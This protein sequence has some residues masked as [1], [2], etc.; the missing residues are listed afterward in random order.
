MAVASGYDI[1]AKLDEDALQ[2]FG[3]VRADVASFRSAD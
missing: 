3:E 1:V 2:E